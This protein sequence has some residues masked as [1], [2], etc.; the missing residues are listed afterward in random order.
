MTVLTH[1][2]TILSLALK[3][4]QILEICLPRPPFLTHQVI[5]SRENQYLLTARDWVNVNTPLQFLKIN[6]NTCKISGDKYQP[7][8]LPNFISYDLSDIVYLIT[9]KK[10]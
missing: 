1:F 2:Q 6:E 9:C 10:V 7:K 5:W 3:D 4:S 8:N